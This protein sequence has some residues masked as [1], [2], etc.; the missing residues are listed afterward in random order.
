MPVE[1]SGQRQPR[2]RIDV[3][4]F[5]QFESQTTKLRGGPAVTFEGLMPKP[6]NYRAWTQFRRHDK[7]HTFSFTFTAVAALGVQ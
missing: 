5:G 4:R 2:N 6:G 7:V 1:H 3:G